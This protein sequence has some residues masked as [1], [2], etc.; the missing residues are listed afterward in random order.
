MLRRHSS[1][2][3]WT[4]QESPLIIRTWLQC[5][6]NDSEPC[7]EVVKLQTHI[8]S[9]REVE[10]R[11]PASTNA[12]A[13][14]SPHR[15]SMTVI[16]FSCLKWRKDCVSA[17]IWF[18][19][20]PSSF[21]FRRLV[22]FSRKTFFWSSMTA[23]ASER[24]VKAAECMSAAKTSG[25]TGVLP[26]RPVCIS[27]VPTSIRWF[28]AVSPR[29][30]DQ[31]TSARH[32]PRSKYAFVFLVRASS[33]TGSTS[34][35]VSWKWKIV[36]CEPS[37]TAFCQLSSGV[38]LSK[39]NVMVLSCAYIACMFSMDRRKLCSSASFSRLN[40]NRDT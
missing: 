38:R 32:H 6:P 19:D 2:M 20:T 35:L 22:T 12:F 16:L 3:I 18:S 26:A 29:P 40:W 24:C 4:P 39:R 21:N 14:F 15:K 9:S 36:T 10:R 27:P 33:A 17:C 7:H 34:P 23:S 8:D 1:T 31:L 13:S 5:L 11:N 25:A 37:L 28:W 30:D